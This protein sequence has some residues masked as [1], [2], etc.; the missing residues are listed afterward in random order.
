M[1]EPA[2]PMPRAEFM[3]H[4]N[5]DATG[6]DD[7]GYTAGLS[8]LLGHELLMWTQPTEGTDPGVDFRLGRRGLQISFN[9][10]VHAIQQ[11]SL[12]FGSPIEIQLPN[13]IQLLTVKEPALGYTLQA[14]ALDPN[15]MVAPISW[16]LRRDDFGP[17]SA[18]AATELPRLIARCQ[19]LARVL[20]DDVHVPQELRVDS[21]ELDEAD[22]SVSGAYGPTTP[23]VRSVAAS[24][25]TAPDYVLD[26]LLINVELLR[27]TGDYQHR[28]E[29]TLST[30]ARGAG[31]SAALSRCDELA[32]DLSEARSGVDNETQL[33][34]A[35]RVTLKTAA[36]DD[37]LSE[38]ARLRGYGPWETSLYF[39]HRPPGQHA[40]DH[41]VTA[42][43]TLMSALPG[44]TLMALT[45]QFAQS[46]GSADLKA[47]AVSHAT[48]LPQDHPLLERL[49]D[50]TGTPA[51]EFRGLVTMLLSA[52]AWS[53]ED[54]QSE[55][56][57]STEIGWYVLDDF[58]DLIPG[59]ASLM[60]LGPRPI[61]E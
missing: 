60:N 46:G 12:E 20:A 1:T 33:L 58:S 10:I 56:D 21:A 11:R 29:S 50:A 30:T 25:A 8:E 9:H 44:E 14:S 41:L 17:A 54:D 34:E 27:E 23:W 45:T 43:D 24:I 19:H 53:S 39:P 52:A 31:R 28:F 15:T 7:F 61:R 16:E 48:G 51:E 32:R 59:F 57:L 40:P 49:S 37:L 55:G 13:G 36:V 18:V 4:M 26:G 5:T 2:E 42:L 22:F 3:I 35:V 6:A 47:Y 38:R